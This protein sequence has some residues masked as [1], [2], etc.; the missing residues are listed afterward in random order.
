MN[1]HLLSQTDRQRV[2]IYF[3]M[4]GEL[5]NVYEVMEKWHEAGQHPDI[6]DEQR[7]ASAA[8][9]AKAVEPVFE[10]MN[11][12]TTRKKLPT[13]D[14]IHAYVLEQILTSIEALRAEVA[15]IKERL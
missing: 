13:D 11:A 3:R 12:E 2:E 8:E 14:M 15:E 4:V 1:V 9:V 10:A 7:A 5:A 6:T